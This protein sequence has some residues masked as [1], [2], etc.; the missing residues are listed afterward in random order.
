LRGCDYPAP[1]DGAICNRNVSADKASPLASPLDDSSAP[2]LTRREA[3]ARAAALAGT[4]LVGT[5]VRAAVPPSPPVT[6]TAPPSPPDNAVP[7][8]ARDGKYATVPLE[9]ESLRVTAVQ[10]RIRAVDARNPAKQIRENLD[11]MIELLDDA[12]GFPG[13]QDLVCFHEQPIMGWNPWT[14]EE[15]LR[16]AI[17][18][19]GEET[20][21]LGKKAKQ[22]GCYV[23]FATFAHDPAW[24]GHLLSL[25]VLIGPDGRVAASHWKAHNGRGFRPNFDLYTTSIYDVLD[26][27]AEMYGWDAVLPIARTGIG[28]ISLT[29]PPFEPDIYRALALKGMEIS[30]RTSSGGFAPED[31]LA[32]S[33]FNRLYTVIPNNAISPGN[34][35]F[36]EASGAGGTAI[37]AP[38]G[39]VLAKAQ[40]ENEEFVT[41]T[42]PIGEFR[43]THILPEIPMAMVLPVYS[44]Y[45]PRYSPGLQDHYIPT[46]FADASRY[47]ASKRNW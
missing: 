27:Y 4:A 47:F 12:N 38:G 41:A 15:A 26:R 1:E 8:V 19:P 7:L 28:N 39:R 36:P 5:A 45:V 35:G 46:D 21:A 11:H 16:V 44:Q 10:S 37:Y 24:P 17:S 40:T 42:I 6:T 14:R 43:K 2:G 20:E 25:G 13:P 32:S 23:S 18:V 3:L 34:P 31:P 29:G 30:L 9:R 22:Y 33:M